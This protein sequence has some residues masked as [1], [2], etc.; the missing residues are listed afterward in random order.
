M[1][2]VRNVTSGSGGSGG[3]WARTNTGPERGSLSC[4]ACRPPSCCPPRRSAADEHGAGGVAISGNSSGA[5]KSKTQSIA[6]P[7]PAMKPSSDIDLFTTTLPF[8]VLIWPW[9]SS[10][11]PWDVPAIRS[12]AFCASRSTATAASTEDTSPP[13]TV[14]GPA[15]AP[16]LTATVTATSATNGCQRRLATAQNAHTV[17]PDFEYVRPEK[18]RSMA[19]GTRAPV[20]KNKE[21]AA[22][23]RSPRRALPWRPAPSVPAVLALPR[24]AELIRPIPAVPT[25]AAGSVSCGRGNIDAVVVE[26]LAAVAALYLVNSLIA[27]PPFSWL[28]PCRPC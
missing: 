15:A 3:S 23:R 21:P 27:W 9:C 17:Q 7:G 24:A 25:D 13:T 8:P 4:P 26:L 20:R 19:H 22:S 1:S 14:I 10:E 12:G 6:W 11:E 18:R 2:P 28:R 16:E 5:T